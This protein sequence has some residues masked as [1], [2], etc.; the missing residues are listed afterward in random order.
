MATSAAIDG[1]ADAWECRAACVS[2]KA[3]AQKERRRYLLGAPRCVG[4]GMSGRNVSV[5]REIPDAR[6]GG[7][8]EGQAYKVFSRSGTGAY[9]EVGGAHSY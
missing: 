4:D 1:R 7:A 3:A 2:V 8:A 9:R 6:L 5:T